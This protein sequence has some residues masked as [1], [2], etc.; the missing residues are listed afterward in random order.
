VPPFFLKHKEHQEALR[1]PEARGAASLPNT[2]FSRHGRA[3]EARPGHPEIVEQ[4]GGAVCASILGGR[5]KAGR[6]DFFFGSTDLVDR[7]RRPG[8]G[9]RGVRAALGYELIA[10]VMAS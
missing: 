1:L 3:S 5:L 10:R 8:L 9:R 4:G 6:G 7:Y 2:T